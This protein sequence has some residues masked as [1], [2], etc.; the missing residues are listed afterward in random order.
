MN[1]VLRP[2]PSRFLGLGPNYSIPQLESGLCEAIQRASWTGNPQA[3][4][5]YKNSAR[6]PL[7]M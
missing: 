5:G 4:A 2:I 3:S 6:I 7:P 1:V